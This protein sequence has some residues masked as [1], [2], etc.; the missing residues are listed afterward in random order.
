MSR[1]VQLT[2]LLE[3][4]YSR[5]EYDREYIKVPEM[6]SYLNAALAD[7]WDMLTDVNEDWRIST[8]LI[9]IV[10]G[11]A[12]YDVAS[13]VYR[14]RGVDIKGNDD[15]WTSLVRYPYAYRNLYQ[16][17]GG[18]DRD[19]LG[20]M[21]APT[22]KITLIPTPNFDLADGLLTAY[23]PEA[24]VL[25][26]GTATFELENDWAEWIRHYALRLCRMKAEE[27]TRSIEEM[28]RRCEFRIRKAAARRDVGE[29]PRV[30]DT[31]LERRTRRFPYGVP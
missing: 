20:Y 15:K 27:S 4:V 2:Q 3:D 29:P 10:T 19:Q 24:P 12:E 7:L 21:F 14:L 11:Q 13:D 16:R 26:I 22:G 1:T 9:S 30:R 8:A 6:L 28:M 17:A 23:I 5:G 31:G 25:T 18:M